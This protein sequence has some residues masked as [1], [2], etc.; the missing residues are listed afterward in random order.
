M[1]IWEWVY[2]SLDELRNNGHERLAELVDDLSTA[3]CDGQHERVENMVPEA[4]AL[5]RAVKNPW[6]ELF[7]RHWLLQ[8]RVLHRHDVS[9]DTMT[10]AVSLIEFASRPEVRECPQS[11]CAVQDLA[12]AYGLVDGV[13]YAEERL[14]VTDDALAR[15]DPSWP[16]F[17]CVSSERASALLDA[18]R[19]GDALEFCEC[20]LGREPRSNTGLLGNYVRALFALGR[21]EDAARV[22]ASIDVA[23][24][25]QSGQVTKALHQALAAARLGNFAAARESLP[26][27]SSLE[28]EHFVDWLRCVRALGMGEENPNS[29][30]LE[31]AIAV[32]SRT[33]ERYE[34]Y[35]TLGRVHKIAAQL[36]GQR[37]ARFSVARHV[38]AARRS[39][40]RL[41]DER[42][43]TAALDAISNELA[44]L[45]EPP[46]ATSVE[47]LLAEL[48]SDP[49]RD[50]ALL[51]ARGLPAHIGIE[52]ARARALDALGAE[53][54]AKQ[55]L[56]AA[57]ATWPEDQ[58][59]LLELLEA[60]RESG[61]HEELEATCARAKGPARAAARFTLA[62][63]LEARGEHQRA[64]E[65]CREALE[66]DPQHHA[67][68][69]LL[70]TLLRDRGELEAALEHLN[71][72]V[73]SNDPGN[74]DWD[75]MLVATLLGR[76]DAVRDSARRLELPVD[77]AE[78]GPID[79]NWGACRIRVRLES[80]REQTYFAWRTGPVSARIDEVLHPSLEQHHCDE[81]AF[82][83]V[84]LNPEELEA[85]ARQSE[86]GDSRRPLT[87]YAAYR[88]LRAGNYRAFVVD[89]FHPGDELISALR[90]RLDA[91]GVAWEPR[92]DERY[93]LEFEGEARQG[94]YAFLGLA[95]N[96][97]E[98]EVHQ[99]LSAF[100]EE[101]SSMLLWPKLAE[102]AG[103]A[104][105]AQRQTEL[106]AAWGID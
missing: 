52:R 44:A 4:L 51:D 6:L 80:G 97:S 37:G 10:Q 30:R 3:C 16:C 73:G 39:A 29:W 2:E 87:E 105:A 71:L 76:W 9:R 28:P 64:L 23:H 12:S 17:D 66:T 94:V 82:D 54:E 48:G 77:A 65:A 63:S 8:S 14:A 79:E 95:P 40:E 68:R 75:R 88:T 33:L 11:I 45:P 46:A 13:G 26:K 25:G 42:W 96:A 61:E 59:L 84:P 22:A 104:P 18:G 106:A 85:A 24:S 92:S 55:V 58:G 49:E 56:C 81:V 78:S 35:F 27:F 34:S 62:Q 32:M 101:H 7:I 50:L 98:R 89:G 86:N 90:A 57:L 31:R 60:L 103:D 100:A 41:R 38:E 5:A 43:L 67:A 21:H 83:A 1:N 69:S 15:I 72:L 91:L 36:A 53:R 20:Q 99:L 19:Y 93:Q 70:A 102:A 74:F 47:A